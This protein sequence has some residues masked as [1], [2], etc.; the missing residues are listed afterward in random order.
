M[1][2]AANPTLDVLIVLALVGLV[3]LLDYAFGS[4]KRR[5]ELRRRHPK[6]W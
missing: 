4:G 6:S 1:F 2:I 3:V 5:R